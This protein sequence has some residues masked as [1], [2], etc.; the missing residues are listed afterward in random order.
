MLP[1]NNVISLKCFFAGAL[2]DL[3]TQVIGVVSGGAAAAILD[4]LGSHYDCGEN[5]KYDNL[6]SITMI[7]IVTSMAR[8]TVW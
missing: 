4:G 3:F 1:Y 8:L 6:T 7:S 5:N 2:I